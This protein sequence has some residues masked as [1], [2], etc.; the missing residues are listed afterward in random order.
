M[1]L[2]QTIC[3]GW[4]LIKSL[5]IFASQ[6]ARI[7]G[8]SHYARLIE[9]F[10]WQKVSQVPVAHTWLLGRLRMGGSLYKASLGK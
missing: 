5:L 2:S 8:L 9:F 10:K 4:P 1:G 3:S 7:S 6:V